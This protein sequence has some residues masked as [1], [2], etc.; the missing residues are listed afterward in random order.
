MS[1]GRSLRVAHLGRQ[2][3]VALVDLAQPVQHLRQLRRVERL[4]RDLDDGPCVVVDRQEDLGL[5]VACV[6]W[7]P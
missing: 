5:M 4:D 7:R 3:G 2:E 1:T 6:P